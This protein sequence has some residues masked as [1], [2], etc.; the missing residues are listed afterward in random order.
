MSYIFLSFLA[1]TLF[2]GSI[3]VNKLLAKHKIDNPDSLFTLLMF[4]SLPGALVIPFIPFA[5]LSLPPV[6]HLLLYSIFFTAGMYLFSQA[7]YTIDAS[8]VGPIFQLQAGLIVVLAAIFLGER[9][10][11]ANYVWIFLLLIGVALVSLT[12]K[13]KLG[14]FLQRG[15]LFLLAMQLFHAISNIFVGFAL[16]EVNF[17]SVVFYGA[18]VNFTLGV[19]FYLTQKPKINYPTNTLGSV[20]LGR[21]FSFAGAVALFSAFETNLSISSTIGLLSGP[22]VFIVSIIASKWFP[23]LLEHH[24]AKVYAIRGIGL[25]IILFGAVKLTLE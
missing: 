4:L 17:W 10:S 8:V 24:S 12:E 18:I 1:S 11:F 21:A 20:F 5:T 22:I 16:R 14:I 25:L 23:K 13:M 9:F 19:I 6:T 15:M 2:A 3:I 7:I